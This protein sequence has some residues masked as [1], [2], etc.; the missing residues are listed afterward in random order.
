M[1][2]GFEITFR[3]EGIKGV[4]LRPF[5]QK[6]RRLYCMGEVLEEVCR[7]RRLGFELALP[8]AA[9]RICNR[10]QNRH[11]RILHRRAVVYAAGHEFGIGDAL[12]QFTRG[13]KRGDELAVTL[14]PRRPGGPTLQ[15][16]CDIGEHRR[17]ARP[18]SKVAVD[19]HQRLSV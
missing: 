6:V 7:E 8:R 1:R 18:A 15:S 4:P 2:S 10:H 19:E 13:D 12:R 9:D 5:Q 16:V 17:R 11:G 3:V 14:D